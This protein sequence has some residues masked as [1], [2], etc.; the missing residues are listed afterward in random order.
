M[1]SLV[2]DVDSR[3]DLA[4]LWA[5]NCLPDRESELKRDILV[6]VVRERRHDVY[7]VPDLV[8]TV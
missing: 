2:A 4:R 3:V 8:K 1:L 6:E 5:A 7:P